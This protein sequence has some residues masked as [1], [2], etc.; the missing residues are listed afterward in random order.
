MLIMILYLNKKL[1]FFNIFIKDIASVKF[2]KH[3]KQ[4]LMKIALSIET[5]IRYKLFQL[6][7]FINFGN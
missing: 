2:V 7:L 3:D 5:S 1:F 6:F 4:F